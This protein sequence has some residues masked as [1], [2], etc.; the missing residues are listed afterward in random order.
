M[1]SRFVLPFYSRAFGVSSA[2]HT[3]DVRSL[4][5][6]RPPIA[7]FAGSPAV[8]FGIVAR[9]LWGLPP[10]IACRAFEKRLVPVNE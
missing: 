7:R 9:D 5:V 2:G 8:R 10:D 4:R 6:G 1:L 3:Q